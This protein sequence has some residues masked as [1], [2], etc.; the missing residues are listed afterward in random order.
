MAPAGR[1]TRQKELGGRT[2]PSRAVVATGP[3]VSWGASEPPEPRPGLC[4]CT[5]PAATATD[6][7]V[8]DCGLHFEAA[9][10]TRPAFPATPGVPPL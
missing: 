1:D 3:A 9:P 7:H 6:S 5:I 4:V 2:F 10:S 8:M